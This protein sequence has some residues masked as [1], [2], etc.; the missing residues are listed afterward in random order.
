MPAFPSPQMM[1]HGGR[2][3]KGGGRPD[4]GLVDGSFPFTKGAKQPYMLLT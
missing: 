1:K 3:M 2:T 4:E